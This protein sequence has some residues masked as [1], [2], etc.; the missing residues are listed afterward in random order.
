[1][2]GWGGDHMG[3]ASL[4]RCMAGW[5]VMVHMHMGGGVMVHMHMVPCIWP[6]IQGPD[7]V[8]GG[9]NTLGTY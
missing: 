8:P 2:A 6:Q 4:Y 7:V 1:M 9:V 5:G 3:M